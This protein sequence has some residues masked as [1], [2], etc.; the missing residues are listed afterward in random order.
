LLKKIP[1]PTKFESV[2]EAVRRSKRLIGRLERVGTPEA[3]ALALELRS[4]RRGT[5]CYSGACPICNRLFRKR[6]HREGV[7]VVPADFDIIRISLIPRDCRVEIGQLSTFDLGKWVASRQRSIVRALAEG[8]MFL[9]GVDLS[10]NTFANA[11]PHWVLHLYGFVLAPKSAGLSSRY[12]RALLRQRLLERAPV[13]TQLPGSAKNQR[14]LNV[15]SLWTR[16]DFEE[17]ILYPFKSRFYRRSR[18]VEFKKLTGKVS[19][20]VRAQSLSPAS[21]I[22]LAL[23]LDAH[24]IGARLILVR[25]RRR[26]R[27][28]SFTLVRE[29]P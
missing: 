25:L 22:E 6:L 27:G 23:W 9:G 12:Q 7:R 16:A 18:Y 8:W 15:S 28:A 13:L 10:L 1:L 5:R 17:G 20:N 29:G 3:A 24:P 19:T 11:D 26:G 21:E 2:A 14:P 4:C